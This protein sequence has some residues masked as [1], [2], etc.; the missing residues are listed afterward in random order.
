MLFTLQKIWGAKNRKRMP[1]FTPA[2]HI[3]QEV[4]ATLLRQEKER[5]GL[6]VGEEKKHLEFTDRMIVYIEIF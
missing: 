6:P 5:N 1:T 3:L 4:V 2:L